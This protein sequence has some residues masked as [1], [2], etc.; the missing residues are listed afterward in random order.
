MASQK[1]NLFLG[2]FCNLPSH[3][4]PLKVTENGM[5]PL[6]RCA[7][8]TLELGVIMELAAGIDITGI[9]MS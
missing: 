3:F 7:S 8:L 4:Q 6:S 9:Y 1:T 5:A 2:V